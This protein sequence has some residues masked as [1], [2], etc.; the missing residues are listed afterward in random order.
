MGQDR[1]KKKTMLALRFKVSGW[2]PTNP[3]KVNYVGEQSQLQSRSYSSSFQTISV[4][5]HS[6]QQTQYSVA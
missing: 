4:V 6:S 5:I 2:I 3:E 1:F